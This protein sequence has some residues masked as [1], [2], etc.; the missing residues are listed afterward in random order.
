M[1]RRYSLM[2]L[3]AAVVGPVTAFAQSAKERRIG[4]LLTRPERQEIF[5]HAMRDLGHVEGQNVRFEFRPNTISDRLPGFVRELLE[6]NVEVIVAAGSQSVR[7]AQQ[8]T[9]TVPIV[10]APASDPVGTGFV[11]SLARPGGNTTGISLLSTDLS[12][13]RLELL[14]ET[15]VSFSR[16]TVLWDPDDPPAALALRE[17]ERAARELGIALQV[18]GVKQV[19]EFDAAFAT[20][21]SGSS[22]AIV[23]LSAPVLSINAARIGDLAIRNR[24]PSIGISSDMAQEGCLLSYGPSFDY[25]FRRAAAYV[26]KILKGA[27]P[28]DLPVEQPTKL[29]LVINLKTAKAI[30]LTIPPSIFARADEVIE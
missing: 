20:A 30:G 18:I 28:G 13:K 11:E 27:K 3:G 17:T 9:R 21:V 15:I 8:A 25:V 26:D 7:A 5:R 2:L 10:M 4:V 29:E 14:K 1:R 19:P 23:V 6:L 24:L 22:E 12:A 16:A